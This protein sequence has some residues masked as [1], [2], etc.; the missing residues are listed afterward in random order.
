MNKKTWFLVILLIIVAVILGAYF[1]RAHLVIKNFGTSDQVGSVAITWKAGTTVSAISA[2]ATSVPAGTSVNISWASANATYCQVSLANSTS[3][4]LTGLNS[5]HYVSQ[6]GSYGTTSGKFMSPASISVDS[7]GNIF[8]SDRSNHRIQKFTSNGTFITQFGSAGTGSGQ[9]S[10]MVGAQYIAIFQNKVYV[11]DTL[12]NRIE[13]FDLNGMYLTQFGTLGAGNGQFNNPEAVAFD[14]LGNIYVVD[15][16]NNRVQIF[17]KNN[18]YVSQ[19]AL[20]DSNPYGIALDAS[21]NVFVSFL[22]SGYIGKYTSNVFVSKFGGNGA[23]NGQLHYENALTIDSAGNIF[24]A[25]TGNNRVQVFDKNGNYISQFGTAGSG[26]GQF[27]IANSVAVD[28]AGNIYVADMGNNRV[29]KFSDSFTTGPITQTSTYTLTCNGPYGISTSLVTINVAGSSNQTGVTN[30]ILTP[31]TTT[32]PYNGSTTIVIQSNNANMCI[33]YKNG[34]PWGEYAPSNNVYVADTAN[35]RVQKFSPAGTFISKFGTLGTLDGQFGSASPSDVAMEPSGNVLVSDSANSR[36]QRF[37]SLNA[38]VY[39][40]GYLG[41]ANGQYTS[42]Q[43]VTTDTAGNVYISDTGNNRIQKLN[44]AFA[45]QWTIGTLGSLN[46]QFKSPRGITTD[47]SGNLYVMDNGNSR[48][49]KFSP[50]GA[51]LLQFGSAGTGDGQFS[52]YSAINDIAVDVFG[53][54]YVTDGFNNRVEKFTQNGTFVSKF[55]ASSNP[56][57]ITTDLSGN[58]FVIG[59]SYYVQKYDKNGI[60]LSQFAG[61]G[62]T[63]GLLSRPT[64]ITVDTIINKTI[65]TGIISSST[66]FT[67]TCTGPL[68]STTKSMTINVKPAPS[69]C[70]SMTSTSTLINP[71]QLSFQ[72]KGQV[73]VG[74]IPAPIMVFNSYSNNGT[75][76]IK[77][78]YFD[79]QGG[80][81]AIN[82]NGI[83]VPVIAGKAVVTGLNQ[84]IPP[85]GMDT[86]VTAIYSTV[87]IGGSISGDF[88]VTSLKLTGLKYLDS[89][90]SLHTISESIYSDYMSV[91]GS[92]PTVVLNSGTDN[93]GSGM[94][95]LAKITISADSHGQ[96]DINS[97]PISITTSGDAQLTGVT[98]VYVNGSLVTFATGGISSVPANTT[99]IGTIN[100]TGGYSVPAGASVTFEIRGTVSGTSAGSGII[101][102]KLGSLSSFIWKDIIGNALIPTSNLIYALPY[103]TNSAIVS[104]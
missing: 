27:Q 43:S 15:N 40:F 73:V 82:I 86:T 17:D 2:T 99:K 48:V 39:K 67:T 11:T 100:F 25:D 51:Y 22:D 98:S 81:D 34:Q 93:V 3:T 26:N 8:V 9:F 33:V 46:S 72:T 42:P 57:T 59:T 29:Q 74:G 10:S 97:L 12:N 24:V 18:I 70:S 28:N 44:S 78:M 71:L 85:G 36:V 96:I 53:N 61:S 30:L 37:N 94:R 13:V 19:F 95:T 54:V 79:V 101:Q 38:Y 91:A 16:T 62:N 89:C 90:N 103:P 56:R 75:S 6:F 69:I 68:G 45:W 104:F 64:G 41:T 21:G 4:W 60:F 92:K 87:G 65:P 7:T 80:I 102:T 84:M 32:V 14:T 52:S 31:A 77:E 23:G 63:D 20:N 49:Q 55:A 50:T 83:T 88:I 5:M 47:A 76:V 66:T 1:K 35:V 58:I